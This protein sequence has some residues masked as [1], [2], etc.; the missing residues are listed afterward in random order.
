[1]CIVAWPTLRGGLEVSQKTA[2]SGLIRRA[3]SAERQRRR[4]RRDLAIVGLDQLP[5]ALVD[6]EMMPMAEKNLILEFSA[7]AMKPVHHVMSI[8]P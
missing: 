1:M 4:D 5:T 3:R 8:A 7:A 6:E 2:E